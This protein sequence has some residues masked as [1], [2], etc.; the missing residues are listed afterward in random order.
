MPFAPLVL[1]ALLAQSVSGPPTAQAPPP[2][3]NA[4]A[5]T[6]NAP[7]PGT[8]TPVQR[9]EEPVERTP[10]PTPATPAT[11]LPAGNVALEYVPGYRAILTGH[12]ENYFITGLSKTTQVKFQF[13]VKFD[14]WPNA[15]RHSGYFGYTQKSFWRLYSPSSP[16]DESNYNP[17]V[18][19]GYYVRSG[20]IVPGP[21]RVLFFLQN[22][23]LGLDHESNGM[24]GASSRSWNRVHAQ[25]RAGV[26]LGAD[27][28][29]TVSPRAWYP[30]F[31]LED[32]P[33]ILDY[34]GY[35][36]LT[37]E[38]GFDPNDRRWYGGGLVGAT[39]RLGKRDHNYG[40]EIYAQWRPGYRGDLLRWFKFTPYLYAQYVRGYG[41]SLLTFDQKS[42]SLR[43]GIAFED[44]VNWMTVVKR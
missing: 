43:F 17:E 31:G 39:G 3:P 36:S 28:Y 4:P 18:F 15:S 16:F 13:S 9:P 23:R 14:L 40:L 27:H 2:A 11:P 33:R 20:D 37:A 22:A 21:G 25:V 35:G 29:L 41:E 10:Y 1:A 42:T 26:Y 32:N 5:P 44:K 30:V 24:D 34:Y 12:K 38:Y 8:P 19:Y 7:P 6:P